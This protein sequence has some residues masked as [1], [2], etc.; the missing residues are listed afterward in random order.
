MS[1]GESIVLDG[2]VDEPM[3]DVVE[4]PAEET[5]D[6]VEIDEGVLDQEVE[7]EQEPTEEQP[8]TTKAIN[9]LLKTLKASNP[10]AEKELRKAF[11]SHVQYSQHFQTPVEA[12][13][14]KSQIEALGGVEGISQLQA[15]AQSIDLVDEGIA[16]GNKEIID[17]IFADAGLSKGFADKLLPYALDKLEEVNPKAY[18]SVMRGHVV[19]ALESAGLNDVFTAVLG[20]LQ[21]N[22]PEDARGLIQRAQQWFEGQKQNAQRN[23]T[24]GPDPD[25]EK[26]ESDRRSFNEE[27]EKTFKG[28]CDRGACR[29]RDAE[30]DKSLAPYLKLR[31]FGEQ[32]LTDF[33]GAIR[34][35]VTSLLSKDQRYRRQ[36]NA[37]FS[38]PRRDQQKIIEYMGTQAALVVPR[39][40]Q[41][42]WKL[43]EYGALPKSG[44]QQQNSNGNGAQRSTGMITLSKK[45]ALDDLQETEGYM[46]MYLGKRGVMKSGPFKGRKVT[47]K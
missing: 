2:M 23:K 12:Q 38:N 4:T 3:E 17:D 43:R 40:I 11:N 8:L 42:V 13:E 15:K 37:N 27:R 7:Q 31:K 39:A 32:G 46:E 47:W 21:N 20:A 14:A 22:K 35:E 28:D 30:I 5:T 44:Q 41:N 45:P 9:E 34:R 36:I 6:Q 33:K 29:A 25:R 26:L 10:Q 1:A 18:E 16:S 19:G 24:S